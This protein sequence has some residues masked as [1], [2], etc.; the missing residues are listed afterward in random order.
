MNLYWRY[1]PF[2]PTSY[3]PAPLIVIYML[4]KSLCAILVEK[5]SCI[6]G[7]QMCLRRCE[8]DTS[9]ENRLC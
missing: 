6:R 1:L 5:Y 8:S 3:L 4:I 2:T 9:R 7:A